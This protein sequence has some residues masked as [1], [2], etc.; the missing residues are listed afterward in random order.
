MKVSAGYRTQARLAHPPY[1]SSVPHIACRKSETTHAR[2]LTS[3]HSTLHIRSLSIIAQHSHVGA[4][5][6]GSVPCI[7]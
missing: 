3:A 7:A 4:R 6:A 5:T 1:A 2:E